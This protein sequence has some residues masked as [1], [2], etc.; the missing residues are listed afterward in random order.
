MVHL[1]DDHV[2]NG[3]IS[4]CDHLQTIRPTGPV[5]G[6]EVNSA[7]RKPMPPMVKGKLATSQHLTRSDL[8]H[9]AMLHHVGRRKEVDN[10][11]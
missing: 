6:P 8:E 3:R 2:C 4:D 11:G 10:F 1:G 9:D 7:L 5:R